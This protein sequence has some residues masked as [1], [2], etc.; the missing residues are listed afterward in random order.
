M[1]QP[2]S[3]TG[4]GGDPNGG[5]NGAGIGCGGDAKANSGGKVVAN[6]NS[7]KGKGI[8]GGHDSAGS[9]PI[10]LGYT[11]DTKN[12]ISIT[13]S[14]SYNGVVTLEQ[15]FTNHEGRYEAGST[16]DLSYVR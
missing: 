8:G 15:G 4:A 12:D 3:A 16:P 10:T 11:D 13:A 2:N 7:N 1:P 5:D 9:T 6:A 14:S